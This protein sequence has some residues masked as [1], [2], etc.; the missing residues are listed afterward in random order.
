MKRCRPLLLLVA[1]IVSAASASFAAQPAARNP[2]RERKIEEAL[3]A[4]S[5]ALVPTLRRATEA[6]DSGK[7]AEAEPLYKEVLA[8]APNFTPAMRRLGG[9]LV[10][11]GRRADGLALMNQAV[12]I[13]RSPENLIS[14]AGALGYGPNGITTS[15]ADLK[16]AF[17]LAKEAAQ[18]NRD[19]E[20]DAYD[21]M[22]AQLALGLQDKTSF[23]LA[24][25]TLTTKYPRAASTHYFAAVAAAID[26]R[27]EQAENEIR[28]A[29]RLGFPHEAAEAF[30]A[31]GVH[32][33]ANVWRY[34]RYTAYLFIA[35]AGGLLLLFIAGRLL[36]SWT[37]ASIERADPNVLATDSER[38]LRRTYRALIDCAGAY[39]YLSLPFVLVLVVGGT[40]AI[41]YGFMTL[42]RIP[43]KIVAFLVIAAVVTVF[44]MVQSF[45]IKVESEYPGRALKEAEAPL[46]WKLARDVAASVGTRPVDEIRITPGTEMAVY[47]RGTA[48]ERRHDVAHRVLILGVGLI[49]G[50]EQGALRAVLAHEYGHFAHRD[51]AGGDVAL[52][53]RRDMT[54][55]A[56]ALYQQGQ[57]VWW[58]VAFLFLRVYDFLFRRISHGAVRLQE[59]LADRVAAHIYGPAAFEAGLRHVVARSVEFQA[60]V[61]LELQSAVNGKRPV[62]NLYALP[63]LPTVT[64]N[65]VEQRIADAMC[66]PTTEDDTHPG[67]SDRFRLIE[68]V[69]YNGP[70]SDS[71]PVWDL[72]AERQRVMTEMTATVARQVSEATAMAT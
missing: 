69:S 44:K 15:T 20:D 3:A 54:M 47:E 7:Y 39:Y 49:N 19:P 53:V 56:I 64:S 52:R 58:N 8:S 67:P 13:D 68:H 24:V 23:R 46:L 30:L 27:W 38:S 45:F 62:T 29:E 25:D 61:T 12:Q 35:W 37:L 28:E 11:L 16:A 51:T 32:S 5:P 2:S 43:I 22:V 34:A 6:L 17:G 55:F 21:A 48:S 60:A 57:A 71:A 31:S 14:L 18:A 10:Q 42:G 65:D 59:V 70:R 1:A 66:R 63:P 72:F 50:F 4:A 26:G 33:R 36:S 41:V 40:A 9:V